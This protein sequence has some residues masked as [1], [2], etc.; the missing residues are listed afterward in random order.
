ML[1]TTLEKVTPQIRDFVTT[2]RTMLI[3]GKWTAAKSGKTF[4]VFDP[5]TGETMAQS[6]PAIKKISTSR[7]KPLAE[8]SRS[9]HGEK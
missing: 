3:D 5:A 6:R 1:A 2:T 4:P 8:P 7:L 9:V